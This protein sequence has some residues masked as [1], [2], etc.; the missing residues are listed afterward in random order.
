[1]HK[2]IHR[3]NRADNVGMKQSVSYARFG[4]FKS[5]LKSF[6]NHLIERLGHE[7]YFTN[8]V[9]LIKIQRYLFDKIELASAGG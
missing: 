9:Y 2:C 7:I 8:K 3:V 1:M 4:V 5:V 6:S